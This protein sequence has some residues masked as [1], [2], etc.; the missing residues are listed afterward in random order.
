MAATVNFHATVRTLLRDQLLDAAL[1]LIAD[2]GWA[3]VRMVDV[4]AA[5]GVSRQTVYNE[6][7]SKTGLAEALVARETERFLTG[8]RERLDAHP[9]Q[10]V[11]A[12]MAAVEYTLNAAA[13]NPLLKAVLTATRGGSDDLLPL[14]TTQSEPIQTAATTMLTAYAREHWP[15]LGLDDEELGIVLDSLVRLTVSRIVL[16]LATPAE[17]ARQIGWLI[18]HVLAST[19][20][21]R[22]SG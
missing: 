9:G 14:I 19:A 20:A 5:I 15:Q 13:D 16:P 2:R 1:G 8:I 4:A 11:E 17:A 12:I 10:V 6:F 21:P 7:G 22:T 18:S 3:Q